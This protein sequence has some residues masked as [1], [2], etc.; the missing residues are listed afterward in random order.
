MAFSTFDAIEEG[1]TEIRADE[2]EE[3]EKRII[4]MKTNNKKFVETKNI[5][6]LLLLKYFNTK[7]TN[8][9]NDKTNFS[10]VTKKNKVIKRSSV[11]VSLSKILPITSPD[12]IYSNLIPLDIIIYFQKSIGIKE[13]EVTN[14]NL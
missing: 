11:F 3:Q 13:I 5:N 10:F 7:K 12:C 9:I 6:F 14:K 8:I 1:E 4:M 2:N